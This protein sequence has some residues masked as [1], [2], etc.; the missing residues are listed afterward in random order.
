VG[1]D[2]IRVTPTVVTLV[3]TVGGTPQMSAYAGCK[4][5]AVAHFFDGRR[6]VVYSQHSGRNAA[7]WHHPRPGKDA[8]R[9]NLI[10]SDLDFWVDRIPGNLD[11][12]SGADGSRREREFSCGCVDSSD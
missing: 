12:Q 8:S 9:T 6:N 10:G 4:G 2:T 11:S 1:R 7:F 3:M 5:T